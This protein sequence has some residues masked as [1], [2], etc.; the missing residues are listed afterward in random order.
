MFRCWSSTAFWFGHFGSSGGPRVPT[1]PSE[2]MRVAMML[3]DQ[4]PTFQLWLQDEL[5]TNEYVRWLPS[6]PSNIYTTALVN[7][8]HIE[9]SECWATKNRRVQQT[10][11]LTILN[12]KP[13]L[14]PYPHS[15]SHS[16]MEMDY[17]CPGLHVSKPKISWNLIGRTAFVAEIWTT[18]RP[19]FIIEH[20]QWKIRKIYVGNA[21]S[22]TN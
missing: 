5:C 14:L 19:G 18:S 12:A 11:C 21:G 1:M 6:S 20:R 2:A 10:I 8:W 7:R 22:T 4:Q 13:R 15:N 3:P 9:I 16:K 17:W